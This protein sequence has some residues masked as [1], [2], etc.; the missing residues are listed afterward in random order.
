MVV[1]NYKHNAYYPRP[2]K[3]SGLICGSRRIRHYHG[4][5]V[6]SPKQPSALRP[7]ER[8]SK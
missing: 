1:C 3:G 6:V 5:L 7:R 8:D 4:F 2:D